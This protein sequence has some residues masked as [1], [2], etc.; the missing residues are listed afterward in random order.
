[1]PSLG[2]IRYGY[3]VRGKDE[4]AK[5]L[6]CGCVDC[7][8]ER[9]V[10]IR[11]GKPSHPRCHPCSL[12]AL[13][14]ASGQNHYNWK[15]GRI[16]K[17]DGYIIVL[18]PPDDFYRT[19]GDGKGYVGEHRLVMAKELGRCLNPWEVVHH[20]NGKRDDNRIENLQ[21]TSELGNRQISFFERKLEKMS[22]ENRRLK[23]Q[24]K[25][26][27]FHI[28]ELQRLMMENHVGT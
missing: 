3:E 25:I 26:F 8:K 1:M 15:G 16:M 2:E 13:S 21:L 22:D 19:M 6:Y 18:L 5:F 14:R 4:R 24:I 12:K 10:R 17:P 23:L 20:K 9:W 27:E 11:K 7:G 28:K